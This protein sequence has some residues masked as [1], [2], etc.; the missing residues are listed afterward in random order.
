M[1]DP[2]L[3]M[4]DEPSSSLDP[5]GRRDVLDILRTL[6]ERGISVFYSTHILD[7]VERVADYI[8]IM[9]DG[10]VVREGD[11]R[12]LMSTSQD[13]FRL[14]VESPADKLAAALD[15]LPWV[16]GVEPA[17]SD[18]ART[19][20]MVDVEDGERAKRALPRAV[21]DADF[22]LIGC[23]LAQSRLEDIFMESVGRD[24]D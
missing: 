12:V 14:T 23:E 15:A 18:A 5:I 11:M 21:I 17:T 16:R 3:V 7:D 24:Q 2:R 4:L 22:V 19:T 10:R 6:R 20:V 8:A 1:G 13:R 9:K